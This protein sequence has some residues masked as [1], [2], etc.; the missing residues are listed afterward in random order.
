[1]HIKQ[2]GEQR[3]GMHSMESASINLLIYSMWHSSY[4]PTHYS[5]LNT[6]IQ[7]GEE[8]EKH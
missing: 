7:R 3:W 4:V 1:M 6:I 8:K 5:A 2:M